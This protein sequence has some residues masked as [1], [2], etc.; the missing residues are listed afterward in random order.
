VARQLQSETSFRIERSTNA[1]KFALLTTVAAGVVTFT[2]GGLRA[3][4]TYYYRVLAVNASGTSAASNV[5][6]ATTPRK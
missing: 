4:E 3:G 6:S 1:N 2:D 5:A